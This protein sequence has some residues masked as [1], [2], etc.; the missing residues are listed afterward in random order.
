MNKIE[1][2]SVIIPSYNRAKH[3]TKALD[4]VYAQTYRPIEVIVVD[5]G[6]TDNT[7][8][9]IESWA[10]TNDNDSFITRY[11]CQEN[12][13]APAARNTGIKEAKGKYL[14]FFDSDDI[15]LPKK[16]EL[17]I[18]LMEKEDTSL[19]ICDYEHV[20]KSKNFLRKMSN[21]R[22]L[23]EFIETFVGQHTS[24]GIIRKD[25]LIKNKLLWN[26]KIKKRQD[27]DF[28]TK[29]AILVPKISYIEE[30]LFQWVRHDNSSIFGRTKMTR[31]RYWDLWYS[32]AVF[33]LQNVNK[34]SIKRYKSI[35]YYNKYLV[36]RF[37][38][39]PEFIRR[40]TSLKINV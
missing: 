10:K 17:Q 18:A 33:C 19:C 30:L 11:V 6:S 23:N 39:I 25:F 29:I 15:L 27:T 38:R 20:D 16:L 24:I 31:K 35:F 34:I 37:L 26:P 13:G 4:S 2:A 21:N 32:M 36:R 1:V 9:V 5:D 8:E 14:Q 22:S 12:G 28:Y 3:I 7:K 40:W